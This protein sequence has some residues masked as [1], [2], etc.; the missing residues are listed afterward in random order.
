MP[1]SSAQIVSSDRIPV[2]EQ[3]SLRISETFFSLQGESSLSGFPTTFIRLT[4][5]PLRCSYCDSEYAFHGGERRRIID[6]IDL[7]Q[8]NQ[9][10]YVCVTGGEPLAQPQVHAL[11]TGLCDAQCVVSLETSG[12]MAIDA[13]DS[14]V[15]VILDIKTPSS[16]ESSRNRLENLPQLKAKDEVKFVI[17]NKRDFDFSRR[18]VEE[19]LNANPASILFSPVYESLAPVQLAEWILAEK[20]NVRFQTQLHKTLWGDKAGV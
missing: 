2:E 13:V 9:S 4:G 11:L 6:L 12:A 17:A 18:F 14:R 7:A 16:N 15:K 20:L 10:P 19:E 3:G 5:C 8:H 1:G